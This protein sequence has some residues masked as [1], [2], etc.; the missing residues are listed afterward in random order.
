MVKEI[1]RY[2]EE[3]GKNLVINFLYNLN[4][5]KIQSG[6]ANITEDTENQ[7]IIYREIER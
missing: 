7:L 2:K 6:L 1:Y 5:A 4:K 3:I